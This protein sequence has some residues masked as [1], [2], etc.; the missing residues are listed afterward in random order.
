[1][2]TLSKLARRL[3]S[4]FAASRRPNGQDSRFKEVFGLS[5]VA[6]IWASPEGIILRANQS[7]A[8]LMGYSVDELEN[9]PY[10]RLLLPEDRDEYRAALSDEIASG[11]PPRDW[12]RRYVT[13]DGR[14]VWGLRSVTMVRSPSG[15]L[16]HKFVMIQDITDRKE[17]QEALQEREHTLA[18]LN[19]MAERLNAEQNLEALLQT[20][21]DAGVESTG[22]Q[23]GALY[24]CRRIPDADGYRLHA[25]SGID[26]RAFESLPITRDLTLFDAILESTDVTRWDDVSTDERLGGSDDPDAVRS[27]LAVPLVAR[28]SDVIGALFLGHRE[29]AVFKERSERI[30]AGLASLA[31]LAIEKASLFDAAQR[32]IERRRAIEASLNESEA[33]FRDFAEA[34]SDLLWETDDKFR[35]TSIV[36]DCHAVLGLPDERIIGS[37]RWEWIGADL[38]DPEWRRHKADHEAK[39]PFRNF[40]YRVIDEG[41]ATRWISTN[42]RPFFDRNGRF[43]GYR[44][45]S[46]NIAARKHAEAKL[47][48][49]ARQ[50]QSAAVLSQLALQ[51][52]PREELYQV[53]V[54][55][56]SRTLGVQL[57]GI[58]ELSADR[59]V[60]RLCAG[61]GWP[62]HSVSI[63]A[64]PADYC[65]PLTRCLASD[66]PVH[67]SRRSFN[68]IPGLENESGAG[69]AV[70][71]GEK[72]VRSGILVV[73][74][75]NFRAFSESDI[76]FLRSVSFVLAADAEQRKTEG[77]LK[78]RDR[79]LAAA[80][81]GILITDATEFDSPL[82]YVN[83]AFE[84]ITGYSRDEVTGRNAR[85]L[86]G[87]ETDKNTV[88]AIRS[89]VEAEE[90]F[91]GSILNYRK[92]GTPFWNALTISPIAGENGATSHFVGLLSDETERLE[93]E[94]RLKQAQKM[95]ALGH[96]TGGVAHDFNNLL[97]VILGNSE[98]L[99]EEI[100]DTDLKEI[101]DLILTTAE[102]GAE[103][104]QRLLAFGRRQPLHPETLDLGAVVDSLQCMLKRTIGDPIT[105]RTHSDADRPA[106]VDRSLFESTILNL[107][108]NARDAMPNGGVLM[109][110]TDTVRTDHDFAGSLAPGEYVRV[111]VQDTGTGMTK[112]V[113]DRAFDPFFT[114][115]NLG[116]GSGMGLSMVYGFAKQ[117][118]GHVSID[119]QPG[120]GTCVDL[121]LPLAREQDAAK[122][123]GEARLDDTDA[124]GGTE[125]ILLVEDEPQLRRFVSRQLSGMGYDVLEAEAGASALDILRSDPSVDLLFT[126]LLMPGGMN[127]FDL[128]QN[129]RRLLPQLKVLLTTGYADETDEMIANI[130]DPILK[131]P[132]KKQQ[133]AQALRG[134]LERAA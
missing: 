60:L 18:V 107:V 125:R 12:E 74:S 91:K 37:T 90:T 109:I 1:M 98:I 27:F 104:T 93:L 87:A 106:S 51:R 52:V 57:A 83:P 20:V 131:K 43:L 108:L 33:R 19:R 124:S 50:Q 32:E 63:R 100:D 88:E 7:M 2:T 46:T 65:Q 101:A 30:I 110:S 34:G 95:E 130:K 82:I 24:S 14:I 45:T 49:S 56:V 128:V 129:A 4:S 122:R 3:A 16:Q 79:A 123:K 47:A 66:V 105:L 113:L 9:M 81:E 77:T 119:S 84:R 75:N 118:G 64:V 29:P 17:A 25:V 23:F 73:C 26:R 59:R 111:R 92:D 121:F 38:D 48:A 61:T 114:T 62:P 89:A 69:V 39:R 21:T 99:C 85:F 70:P 36:G 13:K 44:G 5:T 8:D 103:L 120:H 96:L 53:A 67:F 86:Q 15:K 132:Y 72:S 41:G 58:L 71:I 6:M 40:E 102:K 68:L 22:A 11:K 42:G 134:A 55:L 10:E 133:L 126:D 80:G 97:A 115:K 31:A 28:S 116:K 94:S 35:I 112:D 78:L 117:S 127:G 54:E 76:N